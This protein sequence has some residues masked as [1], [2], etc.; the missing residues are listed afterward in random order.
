METSSPARFIGVILLYMAQQEPNLPDTREMSNVGQDCRSAIEKNER[1]D[2][3]IQPIPFVA[4]HI[5]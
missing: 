1:A 2:P 3:C 5:D 4:L